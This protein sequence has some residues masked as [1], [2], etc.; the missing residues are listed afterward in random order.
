MAVIDDLVKRFGGKLWADGGTEGAR[1]TDYNCGRR[2]VLD[3]ILGQVNRSKG[4]EDPNADS[5]E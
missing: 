2:S 5:E 1:K 3:F 4:V